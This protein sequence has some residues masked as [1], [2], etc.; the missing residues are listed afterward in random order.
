MQKNNKAKTISDIRD[1][2]HNL[3]VKYMQHPDH[4]RYLLETADFLQQVGLEVKGE[5]RRN[6]GF[7][8]INTAIN[9]LVTT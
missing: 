6:S 2:L 4:R 1:T 7:Y 8:P 9:W 3:D 5:S